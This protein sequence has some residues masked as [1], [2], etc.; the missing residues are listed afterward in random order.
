M[1]GAFG[2]NAAIHSQA[3]QAKKI[4]H[5]VDDGGEVESGVSAQSESAGNNR[6]TGE[7]T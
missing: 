5:R 1:S 7:A 6:K 2:G 4:R 3:I